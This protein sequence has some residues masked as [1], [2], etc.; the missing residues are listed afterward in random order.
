[1][2]KIRKSIVKIIK[3]MTVALFAILGILIVTGALFVNLSP[4]FGAKP[5]QEEIEKYKLT[6]HYKEGEFTNQIQTSMD[7]GFKKTVSTVLEFIK[8]VPNQQPDYSIPVLPVDSLQLEKSKHESKVIWFGHSSF[9]VQL[10]ELNI[11]LDPMFGDV[12]APHPWLGSARYGDSLPIEIEQLPSIDIVIISHDHYD[13]LDYGSIQKLKD[14]TKLFFV[15]LGVGAHLKSWGIEA[16]KIKELDW[17]HE[18]QLKDLK[19]AF[20]P[21]RHFSGRGLTDRFSTL[22]GSWVIQ[23]KNTKL[24]FSGD[25]GYG[26]HFKEIGDKYGPFDFAMIECGQYNSKWADIHM[27]PEE[28]VQAGLDLK[29]KLSMPIHWGAFSLSLHSWT[30]PVER[31]SKKATALQLN[32]ITP[33]IGEI[34][35]LEALSNVKLNEWW[36]QN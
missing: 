30:E 4:E 12:P 5:T 35:N 14:K 10:E 25:G 33:K 15:P 6:G 7:M 17:W 36:K 26:E 22:W 18:Q 9:L 3:R 27:M 34:V 2:G 20:T 24:F 8:G 11:L 21:S 23:S 13:H 32:F 1:M 19:I 28:S 31:F 16:S 29:A